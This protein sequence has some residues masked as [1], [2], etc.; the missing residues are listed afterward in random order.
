LSS[1][2]KPSSSQLVS[3]YKGNPARAVVAFEHKSTEILEGNRLTLENIKKYSDENENPGNRE[4]IKD[5]QLITPGFDFG[6]G[7]VLI[8]SAGLDAYKLESH[9]KLSLE[10]L[11]PTID[12]CIFVTTLKAN[13]DEKAR[14]VLNSIAKHNCP[15]IIIQN[16]LDSVKSSADGKKTK[17]MVALEHKVRVQR[18]IDNSQIENKKSV[19]IVQIS[20]KY[21]VNIRC[22]NKPAPESHYSEFKILMDNMIADFIPKMNKERYKSARNRYQ[23]LIFDEEKQLSGDVQI[24]VP[25][26]R[27]EG[28]KK[29][30]NKKKEQ[31]YLEL[32]THVESLA[33]QSGDVITRMEKEKSLV[34]QCEANILRIITE[35]NS[36]ISDTVKK[37]NIPLRDVVTNV[38]IEQ[39]SD[40]Q[41]ME[42][43]RRIERKV[44]RKTFEGFFKRGLGK[45]FGN[46]DWGYDTVYDTVKELD[47]TRTAEEL[48]KYMQRAVREYSRSIKTWFEGIERTVENIEIEID[49]DY[50]SFQQKQKEI[51]EIKSVT[52]VVNELKGILGLAVTEITK[53]TT[54]KKESPTVKPDE[55][56]LKLQQV[57][58]S[59][60]GKGVMNIANKKL[61]LI[62]YES[63]KFGLKSCQA[64]EYSIITGWDS[65][66]LRDFIYRFFG[67][68]MDDE[69]IAL[70]E[71][72]KAVSWNKYVFRLNPDIEFLNQ[73]HKRNAGYTIY[74][75][76]NA[77]QDGSAK[78][79]IDKLKLKDVLHLSDRVFFVVQE[80]DSIIN[81]GDETIKELRDIMLGYFDTFEITANKGLILINDDNPL[82]NL[83]F[84]ESQLN[85]CTGL[86]DETD[87]MNNLKSKFSFLSSPEMLKNIRYL[88][89]AK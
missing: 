79:Q 46:K 66:C 73:L 14:T 7:V 25:H 57:A 56:G 76:V 67:L 6:T 3:C 34:K 11:L 87:L 85:P 23:Q 4:H 9:E 77:H 36:Y 43:E 47:E 50:Q 13:S 54:A 49:K 38:R 16:M 86:S 63:L 26:F 21:A 27:Y 41:K 58:V 59:G 1:A 31:S 83:A 84:I 33:P 72:S 53:Y 88:I 65:G 61:R 45:I 24:E 70:F 68:D 89:Q 35:F 17:E 37:L 22:H 82:Y 12:I 8:D 71:N 2:V 48:E 15:V 20:A 5:I 30:L 60:Y 44:K 78:N 40:P 51:T 32:E 55:T 74:I 80:F 28:I 18:I 62:S 52:S 42:R 69:E 75:L 81:A 64:P 10:I 29:N 19:H 39:I